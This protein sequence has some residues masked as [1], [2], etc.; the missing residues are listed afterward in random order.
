MDASINVGLKQEKQI[1]LE[2]VLTTVG[3]A[4]RSQ[5]RSARPKLTLLALYESREPTTC[6]LPTMDR[7]QHTGN[8]IMDA[9]NSGTIDPA[10]KFDGSNDGLFILACPVV[11]VPLG[12]LPQPG[13]HQEHLAEAQNHWPLREASVVQAC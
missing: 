7:H 3:M 11:V 12:A 9:I 2:I 8:H 4:D 6:I 1:S 5:Y 13:L 10:V